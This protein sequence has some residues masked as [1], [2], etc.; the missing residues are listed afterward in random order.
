MELG[1][2]ASDLARGIDRALRPA[3]LASEH[4]P[5]L[6]PGVEACGDALLEHGRGG[7]AT[8]TEVP[9]R[10][11]SPWNDRTAHRLEEGA[12]LELGVLAGLQP[13]V[14]LQQQRFPELDRGVALLHPEPTL[15]QARDR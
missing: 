7:P 2:H 8:G 10:A 6:L 11:R 4:L 5:D 3:I 15:V 13:P 9:Q 1:G 14:E 12:H